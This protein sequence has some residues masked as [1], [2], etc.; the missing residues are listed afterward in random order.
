ML[1]PE[2]NKNVRDHLFVVNAV[3]NNVING[4]SDPIDLQIYDLAKC[5]DKMDYK[6]TMNDLFAAGVQ[7]DDFALLCELNKTSKIAI[8]TPVGLTDTT[9]FE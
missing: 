4:K 7:N 1:E 2:K 9:D 3:L 6:E 5:F 8:K